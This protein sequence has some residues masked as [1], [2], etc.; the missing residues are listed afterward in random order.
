MAETG[1]LFGGDVFSALDQPDAITSLNVNQE[2]TF[3]KISNEYQQTLKNVVPGLMDFVKA[4]YIDKTKTFTPGVLVTVQ[5]VT[6]LLDRVGLGQWFQIDKYLGEAAKMSAD[7]LKDIYPEMM[8]T[9]ANLSLAQSIQQT[10]SVT[11][12]EF[13]RVSSAMTRAVMNELL[14]MQLIPRPLKAV[15]VVFAEQQNL[16]KEH[17]NTILNT[18]MAMQQRT[19]AIAGGKALEKVFPDEERWYFYGGP[20]GV[21]GQTKAQRRK[22]GKG[23]IRPFCNHLVNKAIRQTDMGKLNNNNKGAQDFSIYGG[24]YN[25]R[26]SLNPV[27]KTWVDITKTPIVD[28][29][30]IEKANR[31]AKGG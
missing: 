5:M 24:G 20:T 9:P 11:E 28:S 17:A 15:S 26:H 8:F 23:I 22:S 16:S 30:T 25:C 27:R 29:K 13:G 12:L 10:K 7:V 31:A 18:A 6:D 1:G 3:R 19:T 2:E 4:N 14:S 21:V